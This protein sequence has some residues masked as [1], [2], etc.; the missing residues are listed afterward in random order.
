MLRPSLLKTVVAPALA[1][2]TLALAGSTAA[3]QEKAFKITGVG[4]GT[5][6]LPQPTEAPRPHWVVGGATHLGLHYG[7]GT[8]RT[9]SAAFD[10]STGKIAGEF[11]SGD[12]FVFYGV[13][14]DKLVT[15]YGRTDKGAT[16]PGT[17]E[18][19]I[20]GATE[21]GQPIVE[22]AWIA[23]FVVQPE[24]TGRFAGATG[25]WVMYAYSEPFVLGSSDPVAYW[26]E[27][28]GRLTFRKK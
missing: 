7:E 21:D 22:A 2:A 10:P 1:L 24:S 19:T 20:L 6:G 16:T 23:E 12:P 9:D 11:G 27:G 8:V 26:W 5:E 3:A 18:L 17:F 4:V 13:G 14:G 15:Y 25:S 28:E